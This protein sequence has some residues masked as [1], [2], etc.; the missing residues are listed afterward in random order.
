MARAFAALGVLVVVVGAPRSARAGEMDL[1][2]ERLVLQPPGLPSGESCQ[3]LAA[4]PGRTPTGQSPSQFACRPD[5]V[6]FRNLISELSFAVA[7]NAFRPARSPGLGG[8]VLTFETSFTAIHPRGTSLADDGTATPYW[9]LGTRGAKDA[10]GSYGAINDAPDS[11]LPVYAVKARKGLP[12]GFEVAGSLGFVGSTSMWVYGADV[13]WSLLEGFRTGTL[14]ML[15]DVAIGGG[16]RTTTGSS[17][18]H[19]TTATVDVRISK[20]FTIESSAVLT[21]HL[22]LQRLFVFADSFVLDFTPNVDA[23]QECGYVP[24]NPNVGDPNQR[25]GNP[26]CRNTTPAGQANSSDF[27]NNLA[28]DSVRL[29]RTRIF[30]GLSYRYETLYVASQ[31]LVDLTPPSDENPG[32]SGTRQWTLSL[33]AGVSF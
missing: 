16:V 4:N 18:V 26:G 12:F 33:E 6:A 10:T 20:P 17:K 28:F 25:T 13:G 2:P 24:Q 9:K 19:L 11:L 8:F 14:G 29:H 32:V 31:F 3:S 7:P 27:G 21:P 30:G 1:A 15:P 23:I 22:G 5:N